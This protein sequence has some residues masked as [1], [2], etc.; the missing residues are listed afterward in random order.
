MAAAAA[1]AAMATAASAFSRS[2]APASS[3]VHRRSMAG[4][5]DHHGPP[6]VNLWDDPLSPSKWKEEH[7][8]LASLAGWGLVI[9]GG[10]KAFGGG[11]KEEAVPEV[12]RPAEKQ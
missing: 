5:G 2:R 7:F 9:Y 1:R 4:G 8:V 12:S 11:K 6:R 10:L 3:L